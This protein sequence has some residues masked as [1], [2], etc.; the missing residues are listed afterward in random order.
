MQGDDE[1]NREAHR[2]GHYE[3]S[4]SF[5]ADRYCAEMGVVADRAS[6]ASARL[7]WFACM[8]FVPLQTAAPAYF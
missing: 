1:E 6:T 3:G 8:R 2:G 4:H 5:H 7:M